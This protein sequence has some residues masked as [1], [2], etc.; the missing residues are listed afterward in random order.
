[1][2]SLI[3]LLLA[4]SAFAQTPRTIV[5]HAARLLDVEGGRTGVRRKDGD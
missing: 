2:R 5:L 4:V 1:M 3:S